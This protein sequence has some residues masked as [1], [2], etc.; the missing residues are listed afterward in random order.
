MHAY[1]A[2]GEPVYMVPCSTKPGQFR[3]TRLSDM[4]KLGLCPSSTEILSGVE[5]KGNI[6]AWRER[7]LAGVAFD[8][9]PNE[10][11]D[12][13]AYVTRLVDS[14]DAVSSQAA[15]LGTRVHD[16]LEK[17]VGGDLCL[18]DLDRE[19]RPYVEIGLDR[20]D[21]LRLNVVEVE[22]SFSAFGYGGKVDLV[23]SDPDGNPVIVDYKTQGTKGGNFYVSRSWP[24]QTASYALGMIETS[25][26]LATRRIII[27]ISTKEEDISA[28][29]EFPRQEMTQ[30]LAIFFDCF[31][32]WQYWNGFTPASFVEF[33]SILPTLEVPRG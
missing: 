33:H 17:V 24:L 5:G 3:P 15:N 2:Q 30:D 32:L 9:R 6:M 22:A 16:G 12:K 11:E 14:G 29:V 21:E 8:L 23:C 20:L 31:R 25:Q 18:A 26:V 1:N 28:V 7:N 4:K 27:A 19:V 13:E 10:G